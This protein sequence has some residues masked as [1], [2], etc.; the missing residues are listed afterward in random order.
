MHGVEEERIVRHVEA[1]RQLVRSQI[2]K[3]DIDSSGV[4]DR[5]EF[6]ALREEYPEPQ[7]LEIS[8]KFHLGDTNVDGVLS[9]Q[10]LLELLY[11]QPTYVDGTG[12]VSEM[13]TTTMLDAEGNE[14]LKRAT[15][16]QP[17][18]YNL[19]F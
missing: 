16:K 4:L 2:L 7:E 19:L 12:I 14:V 15:T 8:R 6:E 11:P 13:M 3:F 9:E 17:L 18:N 1:K 10:E 5:S